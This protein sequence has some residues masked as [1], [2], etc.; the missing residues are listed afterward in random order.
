MVD[1]TTPVSDRGKHN[2]GEAALS[3]SRLL[4]GQGHQDPP[5]DVSDDGR[6]ERR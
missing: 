6:A 2:L 4:R 3:V 5:D 1:A